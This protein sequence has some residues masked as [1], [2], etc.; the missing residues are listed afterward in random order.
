MVES[1]NA[2]VNLLFIGDTLLGKSVIIIK[3]III[4]FR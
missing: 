2:V 3:L 1:E 4:R